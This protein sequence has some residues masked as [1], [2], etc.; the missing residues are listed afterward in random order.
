MGNINSTRI[1]SELVA[2]AGKIVNNTFSSR[3]Y[4]VQTTAVAFCTVRQDT[5][6]RRY[7]NIVGSKA[8]TSRVLEKDYNYYYVALPLREVRQRRLY[9]VFVYLRDSV[10]RWISVM[11]VSTFLCTGAFLN[12]RYN[13]PHRREIITVRGQSYG[14]RLPK[15]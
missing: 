13:F 11:K 6:Q 2:L 9:T 4:G 10:S 7:I 8:M 3:R 14:S 1:I 5:V 15:Y 12:V